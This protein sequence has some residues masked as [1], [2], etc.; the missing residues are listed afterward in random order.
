MKFLLLKWRVKL[1]NYPEVDLNPWG[2]I[3]FNAKE[4]ANKYD[5][6]IISFN[7]LADNF[8]AYFYGKKSNLRKFMNEF[9]LGFCDYLKRVYQKDCSDAFSNVYIIREIREDNPSFLQCIKSE[10]FIKKISKHL[11]ASSFEMM[12]KV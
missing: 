12:F 4:V 7:F 9:R 6:E 10:I 5:L 3:V 1:E 2:E 8:Q 11:Y